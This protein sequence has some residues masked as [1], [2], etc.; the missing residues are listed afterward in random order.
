MH[1]RVSACMYTSAMASLVFHN[2]DVRILPM[3]M[4]MIIQ[5]NLTGAT[6]GK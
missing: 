5:H 1:I 2:R 3:A 6:L 4:S